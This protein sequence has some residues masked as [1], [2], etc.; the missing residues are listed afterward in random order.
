MYEEYRKIKKINTEFRQGIENSQ[1]L[2]EILGGYQKCTKGIGKL[3]KLSTE[4]QQGIKNSQRVSKMLG[5]YRK[6]TKGIGK[7]K[8]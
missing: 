5:E 3:K 1:R 4:F 8:N 2:S 6:C 7:L